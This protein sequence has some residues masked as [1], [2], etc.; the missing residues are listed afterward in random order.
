MRFRRGVVALLVR[1][2]GSVSGSAPVKSRGTVCKGGG[3]VCPSPVVAMAS[4][5]KP[6]MEEIQADHE[7]FLQAFESEYVQTTERHSHLSRTT[8]RLCWVKTVERD[9]KLCRYFDHYEKM[10]QLQIA[11]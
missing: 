8:D 2:H 11:V 4:V 10:Y 6:K 1:E 5:K 9:Q 7:L 3:I